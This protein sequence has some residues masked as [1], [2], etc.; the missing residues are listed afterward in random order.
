M[1]NPHLSSDKANQQKGA[2]GNKR[3][4]T[5][6]G[7]NAS[8]DVFYPPVRKFSSSSTAAPTSPTPLPPPKPFIFRV[9]ILAPVNVVFNWKA[10]FDLW[11][12]NDYVKNRDNKLH[13][14]VISGGGSKDDTKGDLN[15]WANKGGVC[16]MGY[17]QFISNQA[18]DQ[19]KSMLAKPGPDM[20]VLDEAHRIKDDT[21]KL[22]KA[23]QMLRT[24]RRIALT[25]SPLQNNLLEYYHMVNFV[26][27]SYLN[28]KKHFIR[29]FVEPIKEGE[30]V[31]ASREAKKYMKGRLHVLS[32]KLALI[33]HRKD[34]S[35]LT[36]S[37]Q[38]KR[39]FILLVKLS[40]FQQYLYKVYLEKINT[41][42]SQNFE[43]TDDNAN[44][45]ED[46]DDDDS[47][48]SESDAIVMKGNS[49][50][51]NGHLFS[52]K[53]VGML[54]WSHPLCLPLNDFLSNKSSTQAILAGKLS[55][56]YQAF[57][58]NKPISVCAT[59]MVLPV[60][61]RNADTI[62]TTS[63]LVPPHPDDPSSSSSLLDK[64]ETRGVVEGLEE[65]ELRNWWR[66]QEE[67]TDRHI[68]K[69][70]AISYLGNADVLGLGNK[71]VMLLS[72]LTKAID[73]GDKVVLFSQ[74]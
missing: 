56:I 8:V 39:E 45:D 20:V 53:Q 44:D 30:G 71:V 24:K 33:V 68:Y 69:N 49:N 64:A 6:D 42:F 54:I 32:K 2:A 74:V 66:N 51:R 65:E 29:Y 11:L 17:E 26:K 47:I 36:R 25:G 58:E 9:L 12:P 31:E 73:I 5:T 67:S 37:L 18:Q 62:S 16:I 43:I 72:I 15:R 1:S 27:P 22:Y 34:I 19:F 23:L 7:S 46:D 52:H 41:K 21:S 38:P 14:C 57:I 10:E 63:S 4:H 59:S 50:K 40:P 55:D 3:R 60:S 28:R 48:M 13:Y 61:S 35:H 70:S